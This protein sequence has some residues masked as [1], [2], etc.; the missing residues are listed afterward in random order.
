MGRTSLG[1]FSR[2]CGDSDSARR[3]HR[4]FPVGTGPGTG[5]G[6]SHRP[7]NLRSVPASRPVVVCDPAATSATS[8]PVHSPKRQ[9]KD[10][11]RRS[12]RAPRGPLPDSP[13][14]ARALGTRQARP[15]DLRAAQ[16]GNPACQP[17]QGATDPQQR[18]TPLSRSRRPGSCFD[19]DRAAPRW[20]QQRSKGRPVRLLFPASGRKPNLLCTTRVAS[21]AFSSQDAP[22][23]TCRASQKATSG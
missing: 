1:G 9:E 2:A 22:R 17:R 10:P 18:Q 20:C 16:T 14:R 13:G 3:R 19:R 7:H 4:I 12:N 23:R 11:Q 15:C 21:R 5:T 6:R 8:R